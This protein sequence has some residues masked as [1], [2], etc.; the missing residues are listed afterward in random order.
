[1]TTAH[2]RPPVFCTSRVTKISLDL[3]TDAELKE[4]P[5]GP[6][7]NTDLVRRDPQ[8]TIGKKHSL[9]P[10]MKVVMTLRYSATGKIQKC[11]SDEF[12]G[13]Q[14]SVSRAITQILAALSAPQVTARFIKF[15]VESQETHDKEGAFYRVAKFPG[16]VGVIYCTRVK[17]INQKKMK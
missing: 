9:T 2:E 4:I 17:I 5:S 10:E 8:D 3:Y 12:G 13:S 16:V 11:S 14:S 15:S 6:C 1:M 7:W